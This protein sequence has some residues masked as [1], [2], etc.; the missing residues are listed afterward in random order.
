MSEIRGYSGADRLLAWYD[1]NKRFLPWRQEPTPYHVWLS[2]IM[3]QQTRVE[4]VKGYYQRFLTQLP[5]VRALSEASEDVYLKLWEG[6]GY[7]SRVRNLHRAAQMICEERE[8]HFPRTAAEWRKLPGVGDYTAAAVASI[9]FGE[10]VPAVDGNLLR[11]YARM[12]AD[13]QNSKAP[14]AK[15]AAAAWF[16]ERISAR[17]P[18][19]Y[20]QALMD[21]GAMVCLPKGTPLCGQCPWRN[22]CAAHSMNRE[23]RYPVLPPKKARRIEEKTILVIRAKEAL[24]QPFLNRT[25]IAVRKRPDK[26]LLA[27]L[28]EFPWMEGHVGEREAEDYLRSAGAE[29]TGIRSLAPA[30]HVFTHIEWQMI[31]YLID[32]ETTVQPAQEEGESAAGSWQWAGIAELRQ[33]YAIPSAFSAYSR[34]LGVQ[35]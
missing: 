15:K 6:L 16:S 22:E 11:I 30:K 35:G 26:G 2:E 23:M 9:A 10:A 8:G 19:D 28:Y 13:G 14:A 12:T 24:E 33:S 32:I 20:N 7:Y 17:R 4:A 3:L 21:L 18:G 27:G 1:A 31:G 25:K 5:D 34:M 29:V